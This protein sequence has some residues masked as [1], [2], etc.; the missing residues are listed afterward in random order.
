MSENN[1]CQNCGS[2]LELGVKFCSNC[3]ASIIQD[4]EPP[5]AEETKVD[6]YP[7][8]EEKVEESVV[9]LTAPIDSER[10]KLIALMVV[11]ILIPIVGLVLAIIKWTESKKKAAGHYAWCGASGI[12][13][14]MGA[15]HWSG[16]IIGLLLIASAVNNGIQ[17][18]NSDSMEEVEV[19]KESTT[20]A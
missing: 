19:K 14:A 8:V 6:S 17:L 7:V 16:F 12:A 2:K 15:W 3:G 1:F 5:K 10:N 13:F 18:I 11:S 20:E 9:K 4:T